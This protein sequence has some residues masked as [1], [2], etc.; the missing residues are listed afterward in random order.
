MVCWYSSFWR[1][2]DLM[3]QVKFGLGFSL[4]RM[5]GMAKNFTC[6]CILTTFGTGYVGVM[7]CWFS[8]FWCHF[9]LE[10]QAKCAV[11]RHFHDNVWEEWAEIHHVHLYLVISPEMKKA[12]SSTWKLSSYRVGR[13]GWGGGRVGVGVVGGRVREYPWLLC[14]QTFLVV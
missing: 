12:N 6:W 10:K 5:G 8:L 1:H 4:E 2:F 13:R 14:S 9:D 7:V 3:K 11:S